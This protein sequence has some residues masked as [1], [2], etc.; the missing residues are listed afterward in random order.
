M[1]VHVQRGEVHLRSGQV[2]SGQVGGGGGQSRVES[3]SLI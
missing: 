1:Q 3:I 2:G